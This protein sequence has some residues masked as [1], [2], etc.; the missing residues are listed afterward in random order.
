MNKSQLLELI[1]SSRAEFDASLVGLSADQMIQPGASGVWSV[2]DIIA[3]LSWYEREM[4]ETMQAHVL[5][6]SDLWDLPLDQRNQAIFDENK[7]RLLQ[8][9]LEEAHRVFP[10]LV[11][12][13][14]SLSEEDLHDPGRF[15]GMPSDWKPWEM[16]A[17]NT[18][19]H[20][21]EH[22]PQVQAWRMK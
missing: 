17:S 7:D 16:L 15:P 21:Q 19:E 4:I 3:H 20:Y 1:R 9:V 13:I 18:Y 12:G 14:E 2:K 5:A 10:F 8:D 6:G 11:Q 22:T